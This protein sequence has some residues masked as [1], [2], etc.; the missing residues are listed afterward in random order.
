MTDNRTRI[1]VEDAPEIIAALEQADLFPSG[2]VFVSFS[3]QAKYEL[4]RLGLLHENAYD[5]CD[6]DALYRDTDTHYEI[7]SSQCIQ[8]DDQLSKAFP[9]LGALSI[10]PFIFNY[11]NAKIIL[12]TL[13]QRTAM[14]AGICAA[15]KDVRAFAPAADFTTRYLSPSVRFTGALYAACCTGGSAMPLLPEPL[16]DT[17]QQPTPRGDEAIRRFIQRPSLRRYWHGLKGRL[18]RRFYAPRS[19]Y[20]LLTLNPFLPDTVVRASDLARI[21]VRTITPLKKIDHVTKD[22]SFIFEHPTF[23]DMVTYAGAGT[24]PLLETWFAANVLDS[25][26]ALIDTAHALRR[27]I[28]EKKPLLIE[29]RT[30]F[31]PEE[32]LAAAQCAAAGLPV[33]GTNHGSLGVQD[34]KMFGY[35]D[36]Q[37]VTDYFVWG[38]G[39]RRYIADEYPVQLKK[40]PRLHVAGTT[41]F[42][43]PDAIKREDLCRILEIDPRKKIFIFPG[44][45]FAHNI[46]YNWFLLMSEQQEYERQTMLIDF[47]AAQKDAV[48]IYKGLSSPYY[49]ERHMRDYIDAKSVESLIYINETPLRS[50]LPAVDAFITDRSAT[51]L[52]EALHHNKPCYSC[53]S[54]IRF[55][56]SGHDLYT[57]T[58][59]HFADSD[60]LLAALAHDISHNSFSPPQQD[61]YQDYGNGRSSLE[62]DAIYSDFLKRL[63]MEKAA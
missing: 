51:S 14:I 32:R 17:R 19:K 9:D 7:F 24:R 3:S 44:S 22:L 39:V 48:L 10:S 21:D 33:I 56:K 15:H 2:M 18:H 45:G 57:K 25:I 42:D 30:Y 34:E 20:R 8:L 55:P 58:V 16:R 36:F 41:H 11:Y 13:R 53:N 52:L 43:T 60:A 63:R 54:W 61:Y 6:L 59:K 47:F 40:I 37:H 49:D 5:Y 35:G 4:E 62:R 50:L 1:L 23:N 31:S 28:D 38:D 29:S 26:P 27:I 12:D 46:F